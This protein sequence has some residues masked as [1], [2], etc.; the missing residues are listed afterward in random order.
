[1]IGHAW[2]ITLLQQAIIGNHL[3]H[4]YMLSGPEQ[5]GKTALARAFAQAL[6]CERQAASPCGACRTCQRIAQGRY[7]DV[8]VVMAEKQTIQIEQVRALQA[9]A[10]LSPLEG[11]YRVFII[12]E[13]ERATQPA[14]NA[15]LKILEEPPP[16]VI[17]ILTSVRRDLVLSTILSRCQV[18]SLRALPEAQ[19]AAALVDHWQVPPENSLLLARMSAG[20]P[21]WAVNAHA[22]TR[23]WQERG[24]RLDDLQAMA[25]QN[26]YERLAYV[27]ELA[28]QSSQVEATLSL[29]ATW[30]RDLLLVQHGLAARVVNLDREAQLQAQAG[31]YRPEQIDR[32]L[33]DVTRTLGR[34]R[35]NVNARLALDVLALRLPHPVP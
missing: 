26:D 2:A 19:V 25:S 9:D 18:L 10:A 32:A 8:Q 33:A 34:L 12:R 15:L 24:R 11:R 17:L 5:V 16:Q 6:L 29:W 35:G 3:S 13:I 30:W 1:M 31:H 7:P 23:L 14:A 28:R 21:G 22:D 20:R 4:D 27:E